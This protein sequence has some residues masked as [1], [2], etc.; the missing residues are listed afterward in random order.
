M[1]LELASFF[2]ALIGFL[3]APTP[4]LPRA[5]LCSGAVGAPPPVMQV[6][7]ADAAEAP[8]FTAGS[9]FLIDIGTGNIL[10][11]TNADKVRPM[12]S[13][14][15]L[16]TALVVLSSNPDFDRPL[17]LAKGDQRNGDH[18]YLFVGEEITFKN[19]W[20]LLLVASSNDA[21]A[22]LARETFG[23]EAKFVSAMNAYAKKLGLLR[24][25]F[26]DPTGLDSGNTSTAREIAALARVALSQPEIRSAVT[27]NRF[28]FAPRGKAGRVVYAT[29]Q[30]LAWF[31]LPGVSIFGGKTGYIDES[32]YNLVFAAG[33]PG[34]DLIG[35]V[36]G[37]ENNNA[38]F[39]EMSRLLKWGF[40]VV[41]R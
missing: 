29:D 22:L 17:I 2:T 40:G 33:I 4:C 35:V 14:T 3:G 24:T 11:D 7:V 28:S 16:M 12:A 34:H 26:V 36:L 39:Q 38:R 31:R 13:I 37:S 21:A 20:D 10:L 41:G 25:T 19:A 23:S 1:L 32:G 30:L 6:Q 15:K 9:S 8:A 27:K 5:E 18:G